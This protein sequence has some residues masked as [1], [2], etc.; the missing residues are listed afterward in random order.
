MAMYYCKGGCGASSWGEFHEGLCDICA[1]IK[2]GTLK[3]YE[4]EIR[5]IT[6][7]V[8]RI[9]A[10]D[11]ENAREIASELADEGAGEFRMDFGGGH[12]EATS[13]Q[14]IPKPS[15]EERADAVKNNDAY[16]EIIEQK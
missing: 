6:T 9:V 12:A 16:K 15:D 10:Q 2:A 11:E 7:G 14:A 8:M 5:N 1:E 4:V 13:A 3:V